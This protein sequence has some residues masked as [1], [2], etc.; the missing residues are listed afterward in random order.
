MA[1]TA[2]SESVVGVPDVWR[3]R[4]RGCWAEAA[5][6]LAPFAADD[7]GA[8][9]NR[10][11]LLVEAC[12]YQVDGWAEA[13]DALRTAEALASSDEERGAAASERGCLAY[14]ATVFSVRDRADEARSAFGRS[15]ALLG[16]GS[17]GRPLLDFRRGLVAENI[18]ANPAAA[19]AAYRRAHAGAVA[20][21]ATLLTS[22]TWRHLAGLAATE[23]DLAEARHGFTES[24]RIRVALGHLVGT[25]PA[26]LSLAT[27]TPDPDESARLRT[28]A[29]RLHTLLGGVPVWLAPDLAG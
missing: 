15:A 23:G 5:A 29:A 20:H 18:A 10:A 14:G 9:L 2:L 6:L 12:F 27:V 22:S 25:A 24:L 1:D 11:E 17:P 26:L 28:E 16:P 3:L 4:A 21:G 13:E 7:A 19:R 8:A